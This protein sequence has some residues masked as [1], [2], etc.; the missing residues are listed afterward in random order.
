MQGLKRIGGD[1]AIGGERVVNVGEHTHDVGAGANWPRC[2]WF[3][4]VQ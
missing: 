3:H 2:E 1:G 4:D